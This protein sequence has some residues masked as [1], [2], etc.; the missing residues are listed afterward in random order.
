M[1]PNPGKV[2]CL[3]CK[4]YFMSRDKRT[5]RICNKCSKKLQKTSNIRIVNLKSSG[6][7]HHQN[8]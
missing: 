4:K 1:K 8:D 3:C 5:N 7:E 2:T 6:T